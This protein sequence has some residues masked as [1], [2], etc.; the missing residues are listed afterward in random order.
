MHD[1]NLE[2]KYVK[3]TCGINSPILMDS[4]AMLI[5]SD[6]NFL[7][8]HAFSGAQ[9]LFRMQ[10]SVLKLYDFLIYAMTRIGVGHRDRL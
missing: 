1:M 3:C 4:Q 8:Y 5:Y 2:L 7:H 6:K 9:A 10:G